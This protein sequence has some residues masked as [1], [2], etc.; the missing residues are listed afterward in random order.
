[1]RLIAFI[2]LI[3][4]LNSA[5]A[6]VYTSSIRIVGVDK[7]GRGIVGNLTVEIQ[8]GKGRI[9]VDTSPLQGLYTQSSER[10]AVKVASEITKFN[11]SSY[12]VIYSISTP[13]AT[14]VEGPSAGAAMTI[15]TIAAIQNKTIS[16]SFS[17]TGTIEEDHSIGKVGE[18]FAKAKAAADSGISL[19]LIPSGQAQQ[20]QYVRKVRTPSPGWRI[21]TVEPV[22][23]NIINYAKEN[24]GM[25]VYEVSTIEEALKYAFGEVK[26]ASAKPSL[27]IPEEALSFSSPL[28]KYEEFD[29]FARSA[30]S[31]AQT[32]Y[33]KA[34]TKLDKASLPDDVKADLEILLKKSKDMLDEGNKLLRQGFKYSAGNNGFKSSIYSQT[35]IDLI[36][37]YSASP[38]SRDLVIESKINEAESDLLGTKQQV[39]EKALSGICTQEEFEWSVFA[40]Q[41]L[42]YAENRLSKVSFEDVDSAFFDINVAR[43]WMRISRELVSKASSQSNNTCQAV[44]EV[45][46]RKVIDE[47]ENKISLLKTLGKD[48]SGAESYLEAAK[49]EYDKGWFITALYDATIAKA[50]AEA[51]DKFDGKDIEAIYDEFNSTSFTPNSLIS[52]IFYEHSIYTLHTA[53][54]RGSKSDALDAV[55]IFYSSKETDRLYSYVNNRLQPGKGLDISQ[56][57]IVFLSASLIACL[58]YIAILKN[59]MKKREERVKRRKR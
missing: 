31:V 46:A 25:N 23:I 6:Q 9:L 30:L 55:Q 44:F 59:R 48:A 47:A 36:D 53:I 51:V 22:R 5:Y 21:E 29:Y 17:I 57:L 45:D 2:L 33:N 20:I 39:I 56:V 16:E 11:F 15:A 1:M 3:L 19:F 42:S 58:I 38:A 35:I 18:I 4:C 37:Y 12:D 8:P 43:E 28:K 52:T 24:W 50:R 27:Q 14:N 41:R 26:P 7:N 10:V 40:L 34:K 32:N 54:K 49:L 13:G